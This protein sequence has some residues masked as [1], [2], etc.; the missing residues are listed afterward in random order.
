MPFTA[1]PFS[2]SSR[3]SKGMATRRLHT[4]PKCGMLSARRKTHSGRMQE[5]E[6]TSECYGG[7]RGPLC[8]SMRTLVTAAVA[9]VSHRLACSKLFHFLTHEILVTTHME[10]LLSPL[11]A[12]KHQGSSDSSRSPEQ[13]CSRAAGVTARDAIP[14]GR[15]FPR[16]CTL[17]VEGGAG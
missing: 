6:T 8:A 3:R 1:L 4:E 5:A 10:T 16:S 11:N 17:K 2:L 12:L 14:Y 15:G 13:A 7:G 9:G